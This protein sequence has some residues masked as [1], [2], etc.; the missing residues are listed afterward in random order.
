MRVLHVVADLGTYGAERFAGR[1]AE[2]LAALGDDVAVMTL[3]PSPPRRGLAV[4]LF[5]VAR[6]GRYDVASFRAWY[7]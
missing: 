7:R 6:R 5:D 4:P 1:L 2:H 3:A